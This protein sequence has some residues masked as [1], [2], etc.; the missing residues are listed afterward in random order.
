MDMTTPAIAAHL[1]V[2]VYS[3]PD[4]FP[5]AVQQL[6][7]EAALTNVESGAHWYR[8][9]V[10]TVFQ[11]EDAVHFYVLLDDNRPVAALPL[12]V[13]KGELGNTV[14][15]LSNYYTSLYAPLLAEHADVQRIAHLVDAIKVAHAP[16]TSMRFAPMDPESNG[17]KSLFAAFENSGLVPHKFFSFGN[18]Y[19]PVKDD[20]L[21]YLGN[22]EGTVR[23][24]IKRMGKK[25]AANGGK[26]ELICG[27]ADLERG[28]VAYKH[29]YG[30]SW[31]KAEPYPDFVPGLIRTCAEQGLLRLGVAWLDEKP[32]AAQ[33]WIVAH[34]KANIY[35]LAY[36]ESFKASAPGTLLTAMLMEHAIDVDKVK[37][38]DYLIGDD[39]YK[40]A[41]MSQRR[42]RWG[43]IAYNPK[44]IGGL[45][46][47]GK[48]TAGRWLKPIVN[49]IKKRFSNT[50]S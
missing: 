39:P 9:L 8:N 11:G 40:A 19:Q 38:I 37:E 17:Y 25:F 28:I 5:Q 33:I 41:W 27:G 13:K 20:W 50:A 1:T 29:V 46:G 34:N 18:W 2:I 43:I 47:F 49:R 3:H 42:E 24:T 45:I 35:K 7:A 36:D 4:E 22:R 12:L 15:A 48:E 10:N 32:I 26:L 16:V 31:K 6:F 14:E 44:A 23:S 21:T 30:L